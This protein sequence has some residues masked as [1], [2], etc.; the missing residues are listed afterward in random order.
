MIGRSGRVPVATIQTMTIAERG[1]WSPALR[2]PVAGAGVQLAQLSVMS[3]GWG[4]GLAGWLAGVTYG[5]VSAA[6]L[7]SAVRRSPAGTLGP[8]DV[9]TLARSTLVGSVTALV[10]ADLG[11]RPAAPALL[12]SIAAV[13]LLLDAVDGWVARRTVTASRLGARFDMEVD[14]FLIA[15]LSV[16]LA[17][18]LGVWVLLIGAMRYAFVSAGW[19]QRWLRA[20]LPPSLAR[21]A[22][23]AAQ[24]VTLVAA[25]AGVFGRP[26]EM[27]LVALALALLGW[28]FGRDVAWLWRARR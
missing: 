19:M 1:R 16:Y 2:G 12:V 8:A 24:G 20:P 23:A 3:A 26:L 6:L 28:S 18:S 7:A 15:V 11:G 4:L 22:V 5:L 21:K 14:A 27:L 17:P 25:S 10:A 9:V 13:A